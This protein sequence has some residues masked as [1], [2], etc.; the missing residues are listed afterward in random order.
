MKPIKQNIPLTPTQKNE[1]TN[2][3]N[4]RRNLISGGFKLFVLTAICPSLAASLSSC[5]LDR[6]ID[7]LLGITK[8]IDIYYLKEQ[9]RIQNTVDGEFRPDWEKY[10]GWGIMLQFR[11]VNFG[12]PVILV[13]LTNNQFKCYSS[14]CTHDSCFGNV[15]P[16]AS[17]VILPLPKSSP[18]EVSEIICSCHGSR[19]DSIYDA[20]VTNG[21]AE[22]PLRQYK[23]EYIQSTGMLRIFF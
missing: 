7:T 11:D 8:E 9:F 10:E 4:T 23:T 12:I 19:F 18:E 17:K 13:W 14:L 20:K 22:K 16:S 2:I 3:D 1:L 21:P 6:T 15:N 5:E